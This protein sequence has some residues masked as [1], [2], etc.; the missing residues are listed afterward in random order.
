MGSLFKK[1]EVKF[2][3]SEENNKFLTEVFKVKEVK[4]FGSLYI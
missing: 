1:E 2:K 4:D 3:P